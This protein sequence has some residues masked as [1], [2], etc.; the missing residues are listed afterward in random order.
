MGK[1]GLQAGEA[2]NGWVFTGRIAVAEDDVIDF[3]G[4]DSAALQRGLDD[5]RRQL[6]SGHVPQRSAEIAHGGANWGNDGYS[7]HNGLL[8]GT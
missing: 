7:S 5:R 8:E 1:P 6:G 4:V 2:A 3:G